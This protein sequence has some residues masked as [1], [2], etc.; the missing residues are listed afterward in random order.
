MIKRTILRVIGFAIVIGIITLRIMR[1]I[2]VGITAAIIVILLYEV[3]CLGV[4]VIAV[5][6]YLI[7]KINKY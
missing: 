7:Y 4:L 2:I 1:S 6:F 5:A 3:D